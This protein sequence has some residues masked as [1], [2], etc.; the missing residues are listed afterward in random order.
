M[1]IREG[2]V[3][4]SSSSSFIIVLPKKRKKVPV[5]HQTPYGTIVRNGN[6]RIQDE[7][8]DLSLEIMEAVEQRSPLE[9]LTRTFKVKLKMLERMQS[10]LGAEKLLLED[11]ISAMRGAVEALVLSTDEQ[12]KKTESEYLALLTTLV[13]NLLGGKKTMSQQQISDV[14]NTVKDLVAARKAFTAFN[15]TKELRA[16]GQQV[17]HRDLRNVVHGIYRQQQMDDYQQ[18]QVQPSGFPR[19]A[20]LYYPPE[21]DPNEFTGDVITAKVQPTATPAVD[22]DDDDG[23]DDDSDDTDGVT[24][25]INNDGVL[26][27]PRWMGRDLNARQ[28]GAHVMISGQADEIEIHIGKGSSPSDHVHVDPRNNIRLSRSMLIK[29]GADWPSYKISKKPDMVVIRKG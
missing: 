20:I 27:V 3:S 12:Q 17:F 28:R 7:L 11:S 8:S 13:A 10:P 5:I 14:E 15:V 19:P 1:K 16:K 25:S 21:V 4:N 18:T 26:F 6:G 2:H 23:D 24:R 9:V 29:L 22:D